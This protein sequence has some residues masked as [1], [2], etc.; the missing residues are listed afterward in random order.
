[1][2]EKAIEDCNMSIALKPDYG[3]AYGRLGLAY[4]SLG[5]YKEAAEQY[6]KALEYEPNSQSIKESLAAAEK[7]ISESS[8]S[9]S[10][11]ATPMPQS[12]R[13]GMGGVFNDPNFVN[14]FN[15]MFGGAVPG[16]P[17]S[18]RSASTPTPPATSIPTATPPTSNSPSTGSTPSPPFNFNDILGNPQF[19]NMASQ[20]LNNPAMASMAQNFMQNPETVNNLLRSFGVDPNAFPEDQE[21]PAQ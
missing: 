11:S 2:H 12:E 15:S 10:S 17:R 4:F 5:K 20:M 13:R 6:E 3:K 7:K 8:P 19:Q 16:A 1:M 18:P 9:A 14:T 21:R